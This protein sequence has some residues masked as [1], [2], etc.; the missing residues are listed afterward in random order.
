MRYVKKG[1][2]TEAPLKR[3]PKAVELGASHVPGGEQLICRHGGKPKESDALQQ[4]IAHDCVGGD[5]MSNKP[6]DSSPQLANRVRERE[7]DFGQHLE[8]GVWCLSCGG[9]GSAA[10]RRLGEEMRPLA[11][12]FARRIVRRPPYHTHLAAI[13]SGTIPIVRDLHATAAEASGGWAIGVTMVVRSRGVGIGPFRGDER[14][15]CVNDHIRRRV[16]IVFR[17]V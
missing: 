11:V 13:A 12:P 1:G 5:D 16:L 14:V 4:R 10:R 7:K 9:G 17:L 6:S 8:C 3:P 15:M 2:S